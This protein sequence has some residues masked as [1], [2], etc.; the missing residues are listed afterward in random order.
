MSIFRALQDAERAITLRPDWG[1]LY[2]RKADALVVLQRYEDALAAI[3]QGLA[4][5]PFSA[6]LE[7][8]HRNHLPST[9]P[10]H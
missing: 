7:V 8:Y 6:E 3:R 9:I 4:L 5:T 10:C 1:K 2:A